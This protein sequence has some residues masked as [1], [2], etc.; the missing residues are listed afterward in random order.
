MSDARRVWLAC[1]GLLVL[2]SG[3]L[4][5]WFFRDSEPTVTGTVWYDGKLLTKGSIA[6]VP[7]DGTPGPGG[8]GGIDSQGK[9]QITQGLRP[10]KYRVEIR[11][12]ITLD[13]QVRNPTIPS[14]LV[15]EEVSLIPEQYNSKSNLFREV[16]AGS[17][18]L[19]FKLE[20]TRK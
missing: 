14:E 7:M 1:G 15:P 19:D 4:A 11:S 17:T 5:F 2:A 16:R 18:V 12:T 3:A 9:Y 8:G 20:K 13:R 10:G 6:L